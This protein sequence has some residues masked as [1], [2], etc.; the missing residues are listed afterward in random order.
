MGVSVTRMRTF[1][2]LLPFCL[3]VVA[4]RAPAAAQDKL[5][6]FKDNARLSPD[7]RAE[8]QVVAEGRVQDL[9]DATR[10]SKR[11]KARK[12]LIGS[13]SGAKTAFRRH[14]A[15]VCGKTLAGVAGGSQVQ[16]AVDA[17]LVLRALRHLNTRGALAS[18]LSSRF[19]G[20]RYMAA[21][22]VK[23]L[24]RD[25]KDAQS[26]PNLI[27]ALGAAGQRE[28][29]SLVLR[30]IYEALNVPSAQSK[31]GLA[32]SCAR[33]L[34]AVFAGRVGRIVDGSRDESSDVAGYRAARTCYKAANAANRKALRDHMGRFL[35]LTKTRHFDPDTG[36]GAKQV[37]R[38]TFKA[39]QDALGAMLTESGARSLTAFNFGTSTTAQQADRWLG[40]LDRAL[41]NVRN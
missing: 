27:A 10:E 31:A 28:N 36:S 30:T 14:Y 35:D 25:I 6:R 40:E 5:E 39:A 16:N 29:K 12:D 13:M 22:A 18:A 19:E 17:A 2:R 8:I 9:I 7:D 34:A 11:T 1:V 38:D 33:A 3:I 4:A 26:C 23:D 20:V 37:L 24:H 21:G 41:A 32:N 15:Q